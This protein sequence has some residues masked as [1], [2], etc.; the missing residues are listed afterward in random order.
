MLT[1]SERFAH[2]CSRKR[3]YETKTDAKRAL[4]IAMSR[5]S[6]ALHAYRCTWCE[7]W[8]LGHGNTA[9]WRDRETVAS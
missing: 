9:K 5:G 1:D 7:R 8:H 4:S 3:P 6:D 2:E